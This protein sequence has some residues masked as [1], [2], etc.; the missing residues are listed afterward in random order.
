[1]PVHPL[2]S[3][4]QDFYRN[5]RSIMNAGSPNRRRSFVKA[6]RSRCTGHWPTVLRYPRL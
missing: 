6:I 5:C 3:A 1:M 4:V 2:A